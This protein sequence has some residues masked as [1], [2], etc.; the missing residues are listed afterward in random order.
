[1]ENIKYYAPGGILIILA[2]MITA[3]PEI[4]VA[5]VAT[6][7]LIAGIGALFIGHRMKKYHIEFGPYS[8]PRPWE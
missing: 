1:M 3:F 8:E 6:A 5:L 2:I 4:L 7:I